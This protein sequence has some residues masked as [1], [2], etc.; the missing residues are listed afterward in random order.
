[1]NH[2]NRTTGSGWVRACE[3]RATK[4]INDDLR[5]EELGKMSIVARKRIQ[6]QDGEAKYQCKTNFA[7][8]NWYIGHVILSENI[9]VFEGILIC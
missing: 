7:K 3:Q 6:K 2:A 4:K 5:E 8:S 9:Q 1:V